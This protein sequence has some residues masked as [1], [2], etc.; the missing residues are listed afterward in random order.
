[1]GMESGSDVREG[2][3]GGSG[4][5]PRGGSLGGSSGGLP[6]D[7]RGGAR[8]LGIADAESVRDAYAP[9]AFVDE[10]AIETIHL[11][12]ATFLALVA[13]AARGTGSSPFGVA[14]EIAARVQRLDERGRRRAAQCPYTLFNLRFED[15]AF[16]CSV[17]REAAEPPVE[18]SAEDAGSARAHTA[19]SVATGGG[20]DSG[21]A[22]RR[23]ARPVLEVAAGDAHVAV[24]ALKA[25]FLAWH[26][27]RNTDGIA[28][29]A[30]GMTL[31][32]IDAWRGMP[33]SALD[34]CAGAA[35]P[36][37]VAR[38]GSNARFWEPLLGSAERPGVEHSER[39]RLLGL[40][41][42]AADGCR[43]SLPKRSRR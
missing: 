4:A 42:L 40:Q 13:R 19:A 5:D 20:A 27:S 6:A 11:A 15:A 10:G 38:W 29:V 23:P 24:F 17:A 36:H 39:V 16:W 34:R 25:A 9:R 1:M 3:A 41:L 22:T 21:E 26:L 12:N 33:L 32:V 43:G 18:P 7:P 8:A 2:I 30:L 14:P 28:A 35:L 37:L 31:P